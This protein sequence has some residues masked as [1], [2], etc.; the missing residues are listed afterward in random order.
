MTLVTIWC[1]VFV[2]P[3]AG[4]KKAGKGYFPAWWKWSVEPLTC[5]Y[6]QPRLSPQFRH[7]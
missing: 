1:R 3:M 2:W 7:L 5:D 6:E 4:K